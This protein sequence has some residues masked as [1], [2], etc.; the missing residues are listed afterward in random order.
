MWR[1]ALCQMLANSVRVVH[2]AFI[3]FVLVGLLLVAVGGRLKWLW[4]RNRR[5]R[6]THQAAS[7]LV[8]VESW[9]R[10][11][12]GQVRYNGDLIAFWYSV[13]RSLLLKT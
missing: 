12:A 2:V 13:N 10:R 8:V 5:F 9:L 4:V 1:F 11:V 7:G 6:V 3:A